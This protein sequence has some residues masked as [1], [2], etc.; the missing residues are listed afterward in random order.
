MLNTPTG[1]D[2][3]ADAGEDRVLEEHERVDGVA[4]EAERVLEVAVVGGVDER[5]E[6]HAVEVHAARLVVDL[7]LVAGPLGDF[8]DDVVAGHACAPRGSA[9]GGSLP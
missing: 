7:V 4:V 2:G 6:E 9:V 8:D 5:R 3:D 1:A